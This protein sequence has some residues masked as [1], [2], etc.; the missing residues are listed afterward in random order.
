[1]AGG[2]KDRNIAWARQRMYIPVANFQGISGDFVSLDDA[3]PALVEMGSIGIANL[4]MAPN[5]SVSHVMMFPSFWD[6]EDEIGV[7]IMWTQIA[8]ETT[9][10]ANWIFLYNQSDVGEALI[11]SATALDTPITLTQVGG[12][13]STL[14]RSSRGIINA[15]T[16]DE[17]ALD[18][19]LTFNVELDADTYAD[20]EARLLGV[21]FDY[22]PKFTLG[23]F[24]VEEISRQ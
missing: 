1:M 24:N 4:P 8:G 7:R 13:A 2:L 17:S 23:G 20:D 19:F 15:F 12:V 5:D 3:A 11:A 6:I 22:K 21:V 10:S 16:F 14:I 18:G 9:E